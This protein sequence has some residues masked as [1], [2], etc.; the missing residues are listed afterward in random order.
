MCGLVS[1]HHHPL[2]TKMTTPMVPKLLC[3]PCYS[4]SLM[5]TFLDLLVVLAPHSQERKSNGPGLSQGASLGS[6]QIQGCQSPYVSGNA[7]WEVEM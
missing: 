7:E 6:W 2:A 1:L 4:S 5:E 3:Q